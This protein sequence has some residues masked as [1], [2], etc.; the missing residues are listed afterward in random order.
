MFSAVLSDGRP[1]AGC[2]GCGEEL[3]HGAVHCIACGASRSGD[4][5]VRAAEAAPAPVEVDS[6]GEKELRTILKGRRKRTDLPSLNAVL[7][8][9]IR[10]RR[11]PQ[12]ITL[13]CLTGLPFNPRDYQV[14][15]AARVLSAMHGRA[16]LADEVGLGKTI[17]AGLILKELDVRRKGRRFLLL[18]PS[19]LV[20]QWKDELAL[21][22]GLTAAGH[23]TRAFW[24]KR[25]LVLSL[26]RAKSPRIAPLL[27]ARKW[28]AVVVDEAHSLK[29][30]RTIA[31]NFVKSLDAQHLLLLTA[32]PI[33]NELR[34]LYNLLSLVDTAV[35]PTY[36]RFARAFLS[37]RYAVRDAGAL[38]RFCR[39]FMVRQRREV[40][41]PELPARV[42]R[43]VRYEPTEA[44]TRLLDTTL[45]FVRM[46]YPRT[47]VSSGR[48]ARG[49]TML[50]L[51][52]LLKESCSSPEAVLST[53]ANSMLPKLHGGEKA[54]LEAIM[55]TG[56]QVGATGK[57]EA[58]L[59]EVPK[60]GESAIAYVE[61]FET[62]RRL[63]SLLE[64]RGHRVIPYTGRMLASE[65]LAHLERFRKEGG[66]LL[67]TEV[68]GQGLNL[69]HC[70]VVVHFDIPWNPMRL[71]QRVGRVHRF[72][73][74]KPTR[75][76]HFVSRGTYEERVFELLALKLRLFSQ[77]VGEVESVLS[78]LEEEESL[79]HQVARAICE[80]EDDSA[81]A[82]SFE[83][84]G[85][86]VESA[87]DRYRRSRMTTA[88]ILDGDT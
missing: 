52:L 3:P 81:L 27:Q 39:T 31:H 26:T 88:R 16:V 24:R 80:A 14:D 55:K 33:E 87:S 6:P 57:M 49:T 23:E 17:E 67:C 86:Q 82:R 51:T 1:G 84:L 48:E 64:A 36:R 61:Y 29:N 5:Q 34:E 76:V 63:T 47:L 53:L 45:R 50:F 38:R 8:R 42:P 69:Q 4:R 19:S 40:V 15:A 22:F 43:V 35:Y 10:R 73:Q 74:Q 54:A 62:H 9:Q 2:R 20:E 78:F 85:D 66:L 71:E 72:G 60:L 7:A 83:A 28:D 30:M 32:T 58:F 75:V 37:S 70:N 25:V 46:L 68:G 11:D 13:R 77:A 18:V 44:E 41:F 21:K 56:R 59:D 12:S 65:K 79:Q